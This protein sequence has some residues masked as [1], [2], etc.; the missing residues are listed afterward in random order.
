MLNVSSTADEDKLHYLMSGLKGWSQLELRRQNI[1]ILSTAIAMANA[2]VDFNL[3]DDPTESSH[4]KSNARKDKVKEW[5]KSGKDQTVEDDGHAKNG[6]Q[7]ETSNS[8]EMSD[9]FKGC[10]TYGGP[11][12]RVNTVLA[13]EK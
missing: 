4:L 7:A 8:K 12:A 9:K 2:L 13:A 10:F 6:R 1:Q 11:Q 5:N 3:G